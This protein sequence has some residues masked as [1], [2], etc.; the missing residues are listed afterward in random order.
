[1]KKPIIL[2]IILFAAVV[3]L[4]AADYT[5]EDCFRAALKNDYSLSIL[6]DELGK[7]LL[8]RK[9]AQSSF[10]PVIGTAGSIQYKSEAPTLDLSTLGMPAG[11]T[12]ELGTNFIYDFNINMNQMIFD[13]FSRKYALLLAGNSLNQKRREK[14]LKEDIIHQTILQLSYSYTMSKLNIETLSTSIKRLGFNLNQIKLFV[15]QGFSSELDLLDIQSKLKELEQQKLNLESGRRKI[16]LQI[17][18]LSGITDL[19]TLT[20]PSKYLELL[21]PEKLGELEGKLE[22]NGQLSLFNF[23]SRQIELKKKI[24]EAAYYPSV[25]GTGA[26]HYGLPGTN[27]TGAEWQFYFTAGLQ[28]KLNLWEGGRRSSMLKRD[29]LSLNQNR[30]SRDYYIQTLYFDTMGKLDELISLRD[31]R[32]EALDIYNLKKKKYEIVGKLWK[33]GQKSTLD[34]LSSEQ[35]FTESDIR[36][37]SLRIKYLS[38]YQ[39]ILFNI[40]EPMW[41]NNGEMIKDK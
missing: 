22:A 38:L 30:K 23:S 18:E 33:A 17:S 37:K 31:Q 2:M 14:E 20:I 1:M 34:V 28:I 5:L 12:A 16:L 8:D 6:N 3:S 29:D 35:E 25:S 4:Q 27:L 36:E 9:N 26:L 40:N 15:D 32:T 10:Y 11:G 24:D 19:D 7:K 39:Q 41:E 13:G 21:D